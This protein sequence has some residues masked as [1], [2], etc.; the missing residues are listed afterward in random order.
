MKIESITPAIGAVIHG[1]NLS[2]TRAITEHAQALRDALAERQVLFFHD[3]NL[4]PDAQV[5]FARTFGEVLP[6]ASTFPVHPDNA[7]LELLISQGKKTGTDIWHADMTW[8]K[9]PPAATCLYA[10]EVPETGGDTMWASM[11]CA[12]ESL[13]PALQ[14]YFDGMTAVHNWEAPELVR[15]VMS[16]ED[17]AQRYRN[18]RLESPPIDQPVVL[19]HPVTGRKLLF[20]NSLYTTFINNMGR[21]ESAHWITYLSGLAKVPEWQVRFRW[22]KGSVAVWDNIATQHYAVND[23]HPAPRRMHRV[24]IR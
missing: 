1:L 9:S 16:K 17:G 7:Y 24:T 22:R 21:E 4:T 3:Q 5:A 14:H 10:V 6:V 12:F 23:Y 13:S 19:T 20:V 8:Q 2:D 15:S 18:M 11:G